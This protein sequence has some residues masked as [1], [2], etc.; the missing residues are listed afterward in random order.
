MRK[1]VKTPCPAVLAANAA[2][3]TADVLTALANGETPTDTQ[4]TRYNH[5]AIK[6]AI[7][8]ETL[9]KCAYCESQIT[10]IDHGDIEHIVPKSKVPARAFDWD[11]LTLACR[12]CNQNKGDFHSG[13]NDHSGLVDPYQ[14]DPND[15]FL[16]HRETVTPRPDSIR[17]LLTEDEIG[18]SR[19]PLRERRGERMDLIDGLIRGYCNASVVEKPIL[20]RNL[21]RQCCS[22]KSEYSVAAKR[23]IDGVFAATGI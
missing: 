10:H 13:G 14:D 2:A 1:L 9:E 23:Y 6:A 5:P 3:W 19:G 16:F 18:L 11:N 8:V 20:K 22:D 12:I 7:K 17:G 4:K 15:H 21:Y